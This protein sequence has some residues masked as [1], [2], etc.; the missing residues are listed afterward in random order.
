MKLEEYYRGVDQYHQ[1]VEDAPHET[2][3]V[4]PD[5]LMR[6]FDPTG[7]IVDVAGGSGINAQIFHLSPET[8][9]CV[10][11][12]PVGLNIAREKG[13]GSQVQG[14][15]NCLPFR[16][17]SADVVLCSWALEHLA[18]PELTLCEM[19]RI[20]KPG[21][22]ILIWGPNWDNVF[23]KDF[24]QFVHKTRSF[25]RQVRWKLLLKMIRNEF[26]PFQYHPY[27]SLDVAALAEPAQY[28]SDDTDAVH[29]VLC[30]ETTM[31]FKQKGT[32][33]VHLSDFSEMGKYLYNDRWIRTVRV[34]LR[35]FLPLL[36]HIPL[37]RWF[38]IRFPIV[39]EKPR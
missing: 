24:P 5:L 26:M 18:E 34:I 11:L 3:V 4:P 37:V 16:S 38:V 7:G 25:V 23:R 8:Y 2:F 30:Q 15:T 19:I 36:R 39:V 6:F 35:P 31:F 20:A 14:N 9:V 10:D 17:N 13:R 32:R 22:R 28:L 21:G 1:I 29:C 27:V 33:I 12:S